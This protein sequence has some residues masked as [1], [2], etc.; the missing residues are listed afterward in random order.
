MDFDLCLSNWRRGCKWPGLQT[1]AAGVSTHLGGAKPVSFCLCFDDAQFKA[2][3]LYRGEVARMWYIWG[4]EAHSTVHS[5]AQCGQ[6]ER[7]KSNCRQGES[8]CQDNSVF[9]RVFFL[10]LTWV[11]V[12]RLTVRLTG[13]FSLNKNSV[14]TC[15]WRWA[16]SWL[17]SKLTVLMYSLSTMSLLQQ[18]DGNYSQIKNSR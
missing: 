5:T 10:D 12:P 8:C 7:E 17:L 13:H 18:S 9:F 14:I 4:G 6:R 1:A 3:C 16:W 2:L 11:C 15:L